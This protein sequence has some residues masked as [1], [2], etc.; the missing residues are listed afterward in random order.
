MKHLCYLILLVGMSFLS[1]G[2][3]E[4]GIEMIYTNDFFISAA[5][6]PFETLFIETTLATQADFFLGMDKEE[7]KNI[8][9]T[10]GRLSNVE[11]VNYDFIQEVSIS[12][13][14]EIYEVGYRNDIRD[15]QGT[16]LELI[17]NLTDVK[18]FMVE[19]DFRLIV[20]IRFKYA[21]FFN[22]EQ[23]RLELRFEAFK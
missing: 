19:D 12:V 3:D 14:S 16:T 5:Q 20:R 23:N 15:N 4:R 18:P 2:D 11:G 21:P 6:N 8:H 10:Y 9:L 13:D 17:S 22:I 1:C 7:I